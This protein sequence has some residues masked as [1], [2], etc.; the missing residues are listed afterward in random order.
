M[1]DRATAAARVV[2]RLRPVVDGLRS[3]L[4]TADA[5][6][7]V[8]ALAGGL[9]AAAVATGLFPYRSPNHDEGVYL[10]QAAMLLDG[11]LFLRPPVP[12]SFRPWFF[13][14]TTDG[15][16]YPKYAPVPAAA[17]AAGTLLGAPWLALV[18]IGV[19]VVGQIGRAHV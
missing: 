8:L 5:A 15:A 9:V 14:E 6:A 19:A 1:S 10:Q 13:V 4:S 17:F 12:E 18:G 16:L 2:G 3:R 7:L 11:R